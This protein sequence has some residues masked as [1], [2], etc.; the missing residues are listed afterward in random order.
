MIKIKESQLIAM[1]NLV[2]ENPEIDVWE[3]MSVS[4]VQVLE[5]KSIDLD[6]PPMKDLLD[7]HNTSQGFG[8]TVVRN[9]PPKGERYHPGQKEFYQ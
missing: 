5:E 6:N 9:V 2:K 1:L 3:L 8:R 7:S 4:G